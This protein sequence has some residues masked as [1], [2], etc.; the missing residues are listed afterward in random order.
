[1]VINSYATLIVILAIVF[2][3]CE[4]DKDQSSLLA[5]N[6]A[7]KLWVDQTRVYLPATAEWTNR[8]EIADLNQDGLVD[9]IFANGGNYSEPGPAESSRI[10]INQG[11]GHQ[12]KEVTTRVFAKETYYARVIKARDLNNDNI[13]DLVLGATFQNQSQLF[14]GTQ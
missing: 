1:M 10:F 2:S 13:P 4:P 14:F 7:A 5:E 3:S 12:F 9:L 11:S 8:V 6:A